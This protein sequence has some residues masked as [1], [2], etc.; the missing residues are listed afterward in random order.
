[1]GNTLHGMPKNSKK[2][3]AGEVLAANLNTLME[4]DANL[5]SGPKVAKA[6]GVTRKSINNLS[7]NRHD[8]RLSSIESIAQAFGLEAYQLLAPG[9][10][11]N[12][13]V[14]FRA[15]NETGDSG[16][17]LLTQAAEVALRSRDR[18]ASN[19]SDR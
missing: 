19:N 5:S 8:P 7:E 10:D 9:I 15:Y 17:D 4:A 11:N 2:L 3:S 16:R 6:S 1:M 13:L 18:K 14:I 12:L